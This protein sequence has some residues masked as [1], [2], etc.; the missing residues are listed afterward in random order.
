MPALQKIKTLPFTEVAQ[1]VKRLQR[2]LSELQFFSSSA[3]KRGRG[4]FAEEITTNPEA[5]LTLKVQFVTG[6]AF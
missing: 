5:V 4:F 3:T 2:G 6:I 1:P